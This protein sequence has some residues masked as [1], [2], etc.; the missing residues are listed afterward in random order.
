[1]RPWIDADQEFT[2]T[3]REATTA[4]LP[5]LPE[6]FDYHDVS[7]MI[8]EHSL[9]MATGEFSIFLLF[10]RDALIGELHVTWRSADPRFAVTG[11]RAYLSAFRIHKDRQGYGFGTYLLQSVILRIEGV[12]YREITIGVEDDNARA[13][14]MYTKLGFTAFVARQRES[15]QG[16]EYEY[17]LLLRRA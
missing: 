10:E 9:R 1:M 2:L 7:A 15:Y 3:V 6:L 11:R 4:D 5:R 16:D 14:H 13:R 8:A 12:G 17:N